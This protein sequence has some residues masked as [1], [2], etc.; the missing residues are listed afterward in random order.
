MDEHFAEEDAI[1]PLCYDACEHWAT[2]RHPYPRHMRALKAAA[3]DAMTRVY[4]HQRAQHSL[5]CTNACIR[6]DNRARAQCILLTETG[7]EIAR[8]LQM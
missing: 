1:E 4:D 2:L 5:N 7:G 8:C 3:R 6:A